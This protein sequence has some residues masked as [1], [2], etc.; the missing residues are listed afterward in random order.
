MADAVSQAYVNALLKVARQPS[1]KLEKLTEH[2]PALERQILKERQKLSL[3]IAKDDPIRLPIDLLSPIKCILDETI[4]TQALAY[5]LTPSAEHGFEKA[6]LAAALQKMPQRKGVSKMAALL[7][8]KRTHVHVLPEYYYPIE[9]V[10]T[11]SAARCDIWIEMR[12]GN[13]SALIIIENKIDAVEG[14]G[15]FLLYEKKAQEWCKTNKGNA[16]LVYLARKERETKTA[17]DAWISLSYLNLASALRD[18]WRGHRSAPGYAW[19][20]LYISAITQGV[21]GVDIN[22]LQDTS[23][24]EI[25]A[26]LGSE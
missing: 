7:L 13:R 9:E 8:Q 20:G 21:L 11:R 4:H 19:L 15:Q 5:L 18:V 16:L 24:D 10:R 17:D 3:E 25:K 1:L 6:V 22:R 14:E 23:I 26:Y 12:N 2:W